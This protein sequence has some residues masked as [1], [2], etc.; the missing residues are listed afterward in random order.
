MAR[1]RDNANNARNLRNIKAPRKGNGNSRKQRRPRRNRTRPG[2]RALREI[3]KF[4]NSVDLLIQKLPFQRLVREISQDLSKDPV[5]WQSTAILALQM[6]SED[7]L[8]R[9]FEDTNL[10]CIHGKRVTIRPS[11]M[12]LVLRLRGEPMLIPRPIPK[13]N[14]IKHIIH[15]KMN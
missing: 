2:D 8:T 12:Q 10:C 5:R 7:Y 9:F 15:G 1:I 11:D 13:Y 4:Q 3:R 6:A 14:K